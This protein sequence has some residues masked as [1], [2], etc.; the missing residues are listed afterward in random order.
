LAKTQHLILKNIT[1]D[2]SG[3]DATYG[4]QFTD[5]CTD[6]T[7]RDC[8]LLAST[9]T[10]SAYPTNNV[11]VYKSDML[12]YSGIAD[13]IYL[14]NNL[15][16]GGFY[17]I[18]FAGRGGTSGRYG[19]HIIIDSNTVRY[20]AE[21]GINAMYSEFASCS[22]NS[23][24]S[25]TTSDIS[26][27][28]RGI[29]LTNSNGPVIGNRVIQQNPEITSPYGLYFNTHSFSNTL[30]TALIA[31]NEVRVHITGTTARYGLCMMSNSRV[32]ILHNSILVT[33]TGVSNH[34][35]IYTPGSAN[36][37][38]E[39]KNNLITVTTTEGIP[40]YINGN[41]VNNYDID[42]NNIYAP[43][44][45]GRV[46]YANRSTM[47]DWQN[48]ILSDKNSMRI[49]PLFGDNNKDLQLVDYSPFYTSPRGDVPNDINNKQ[50]SGNVT[51]LGCYHGVL[52][53]VNAKLQDL[54][55]GR[56]GSI[57]EEEDTIK[58]ILF[59][60]GTTPL[61]T[62]NLSWSYNNDVRSP[63]TWSGN[64]GVGES[65]TITLGAILYSESGDYAISAWINH[66]GTLQDEFL[67][68][69]TLNRSGYIC[70]SPLNGVYTAGSSGNDFATIND[71]LNRIRLCGVNGDIT[72]EIQ[73][74]IYN[75]QNVNLTN[76][77]ATLGN[78]SLTITSVAHKAEN[79]V[80]KTKESGMFLS[81]SNNIIIKDITID[82]TKGTYAIQ[83]A[84]ACTNVVIRDCRLLADTTTTSAT[85]YP[86]YKANG[87]GIMDRIF[88][89][90]NLLEGGYNGFHFYGGTGSGNGQYGTKIVFD[91]NTV[92]NQYSYAANV[93]YTD[94]ISCS[95]N[96][97]L[98]RTTN[99]Y[100]GW[101]GFVFYYI[102]GQVSA[103]R[104]LQRS[105]AIT[106]PYGFYITNYN[107]Y[108][109]TEKGLIANNEILL[110][111][112]SSYTP[113]IYLTDASHVRILH[114]SIYISGD[115]DARGIYTRGNNN[116]RLEIKNNNVVITSTGTSHPIYL[117]S[118]TYFGLYDV[119]CNNM[120]APQYVGY[121][122]GNKS[123]LSNWRQAI[124]TDRYSVSV[125]PSFVDNT[126]NLKLTDYTGLGCVAHAL[127]KRDVEG[128]F[129]IGDSTSMGAYHGFSSFSTNASLTEILHWRE[130][131][132]TGQSDS[133]DVVL[134]NTGTTPLTTATIG[135]RFNNTTQNSVNWSGT[136]NHGQ[137]VIVRLGKITYIASDNILQAWT[138]DLG[139]LT[140]D[141]PNDDT[142]KIKGYVCTAALS[143]VYTIGSSGYYPS[144]S[145]ALEKLAI[146]GAA[147][148]IVFEIQTGNY[149]QSLDLTNISSLLGN[150]SLTFTSASDNAEDVI[151]T[152]NTVGVKLSNSN[153]IILKKI[154]V[155]ATAGSYAI[156]FTGA[157]TNVLIRDCRLLTGIT[158]EG[159][160]IYKAANTGVVDS[161]FIIHNLLD[162]GG[163]GF[164]F[165][166]GTS[167]GYGTHVVFDS[168]RV[169]NNSAY[170]IRGEYVDFTTCSYNTVLSLTTNIGGD[171]TWYG[172]YMGS[173]N[174][175]VM[176]N[177]IMHRSMDII[178]PYCMYFDNYSRNNT[179]DTG[180]IAN[181]EMIC[182]KNTSGNVFAIGN[183][184]AK[185][186]HNSIYAAARGNGLGAVRGIEIVNSRNNFIVVKNNNIVLKATNALPILLEAAFNAG[187]YNIDANNMYAA[188]YV[189]SVNGTNI[190][191]IQ[192][193]QQTVTTDR[194]SVSTLVAFVD[195]TVNLELS[196]YSALLCSFYPEVTKDILGNR[197]ANT[198][199]MGAYAGFKLAMD[200][201][202]QAIICNNVTPYQQPVMTKIEILNMGNATNIDSA[203]FGWSING[204][205]Q[206]VYTWIAANPLA[207]EES[208]IVSL[209][210]FDAME[211]D[212]V[213][214]LVAWIESVNGKKDSIAW[215]DTLTRSIKILFTGNNLRAHA[216]EQLVP[217]GLLCT[218][219]FTSLKVNVENAGTLD[220][221]F[222]TNPVTFSVRLTNPEPFSLN[223]VI[224]S[225]MIKSGEILTFELTDTFPIVVAGL[226]DIEVFISS[227]ADTIKYDDTVRDQYLSGRFRLPIDE[228][229]NSGI[230]AEF[231][232]KSNNVLH[233]WQVVAQGTG[234]D[235]VVLPQFGNG[236]LS[237]GGSPGSMATLSTRQ[238]D[239]SRTVKPS[240]SFWYFHDTIPCDD[241]TD[242]LITIDGGATYTMIL[243]VIK[244]NQVYGWKQYSVD[245]PSYAVNQCVIL[246]FEAME[247][248]RSG[249]VVQYI[250]RILV[251]ARQDIAI[252]EV[253]TSKLSACNLKNKDLKVVLKNESDPA[254]NYVNTPITITL[255]IEK[256]GQT[257]IYDTLLDSGI[258]SG[259]FADTI[260][261]TTGFDFAKGT[262]TVKTYFSSV[263]DVDR[264]NDTLATAIVIN[265]A[266]T[267]QVKRIS[268]G[269]TNCL[270]GESSLWQEVIITNNGN[271]DLSNIGLILQIDTG[272]TGTPAYV[273]I[274][275]T[276]TDVILAGNSLTYT[277][278][279]PYPAP[280]NTHYYAGLT[281]YL[282]CDSSIANGR[283]E[284][285]ECVDTKDLR[286]TNIDNPTGTR[287][288]AGST[289]QVRATINNRSD[290][291]IFN[292]IPVTY[293]VTNSQ[294]IQ[295]ATST[296]NQTIGT[297]ATVSHTFDD[298]YI[299]PNDS[300]YY[301]TIYVESRD[302]Y[303]HNDT[304]IMRRETDYTN[305]YSLSKGGFTLEQNIPNPV[306][307]TTRIDYSIPEAGEIIFSVHNVTGQLLYSKT[308]EAEGGKH[309]LTFDTRTLSNG[310][311]FYWI[312]YKGQR[313][314]K[315]MNKY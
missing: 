165:H 309:S 238:L 308:I 218:E 18:Y 255:E 99:A 34:A 293:L 177:R 276:S 148:N 200:L 98:S 87:T 256:A 65:D 120:Y 113:G 40:I 29:S 212:N 178:Y 288:V 185:I 146:C 54:Y 297:S 286:I 78:Y 75:N 63:I 90:N 136:L 62:A 292:T 67:S 16:E 176:G 193:W 142:I 267:V 232:L 206:P 33:G 275:D 55:G 287:D 85:S 41:S 73:T 283:N 242:V 184:R 30:D 226:Y 23:V 277:F 72:V 284:I 19:E 9:T 127:V 181:N 94:F 305:I 190:N 304:V 149:N 45:V 109:T 281:A 139:A 278:K 197:R 195:T 203:T 205:T 56:E 64:L 231:D 2:V 175:A 7:I 219:D 174:G 111:A 302:N 289:I 222:A 161:I 69:D 264:N 279:T 106:N 315:R 167:S 107:I 103:N 300:V 261:V 166:G 208:A 251:T 152:T 76:I 60:S 144:L 280:W 237:F 295:M 66:L 89:V 229:F 234:S 189:G 137:S 163:I 296:E 105:T 79:V 207:I 257:F 285:M 125:N 124:T 307:N 110:N 312:E 36:G 121:A 138:N 186:V 272:E 266:M 145:D 182:T 128:I 28:W 95:H 5:S 43:K 22:Y 10:I 14:V 311:Y 270:S 51:A 86:L 158:A 88:I 135:W 274:R 38:Y 61:T 313:L 96:V 11:P 25:R 24:S 216:I 122:E 13:S 162:G 227:L 221:D 37:W 180:L 263:L 53:S 32:R 101:R 155:D 247:M 172:V 198:T 210:Q 143:G 249:D 50:R 160:P 291:Y 265:P 15:V 44:Y 171:I 17:G 59:N 104:I 282:L 179:T 310:I 153:N 3:T 191:D 228:Y 262:Y 26:T 100:T 92:S 244:Y 294:G 97:L 235:T 71:A 224:S 52:Y 259:F 306:K 27:S 42:N 314:V 84:D 187:Q 204:I 126:Q 116:E 70:A 112:A 253:L 273:I 81:N 77:A 211:K 21:Y 47:T 46:G 215:N 233:K 31:N 91:S 151:L 164:Y 199:V 147:G 192:T 290:G 157:C 74:G 260:T 131:L 183:S 236:M 68:D 243:S 129:R 201:G 8:K 130:G 39:I 173:C 250:D 271:M 48:I 83:F 194:H 159:S 102:N 220:Y 230:P 301:L 156:Q 115:G 20:Q 57:T 4:I 1:V 258:L 80:L 114:N 254:L 133:V 150:N 119:D 225:G 246:V 93:Y 188:K 6:I 299:V 213:F 154:T 245:L 202:I 269:S 241:Y 298:T 123:S 214:N 132:I 268:G 209:G 168:N 134:C 58:A 169:T 196:D 217:D 240:L 141:Y 12:P 140:D 35:G 49:N 248:S 82:A 117:T 239:L 303:P 118:A 170:G 108:N 252:R 223:T